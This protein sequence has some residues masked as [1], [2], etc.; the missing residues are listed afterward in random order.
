MKAKV[1]ARRVNGNALSRN[2][3]PACDTTE[4][5]RRGNQDSDV[6]GGEES[7]ALG[8]GTMW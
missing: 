8:A 5:E 2:T 4:M 6:F 3:T 1:G 7:G